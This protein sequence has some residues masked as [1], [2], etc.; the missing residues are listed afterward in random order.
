[1][2]ER[3]A[4]KSR[5]STCTRISAPEVGAMA[6]CKID[7]SVASSQC[8]TSWAKQAL[9]LALLPLES[10][11]QLPS[12]TNRLKAFLSKVVAALIEEAAN[13]VETAEK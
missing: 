1:M 5:Y 8:W 9:L 12:P 6:R 10:A 3:T 4:E 7:R 13:H 11:L 2:A